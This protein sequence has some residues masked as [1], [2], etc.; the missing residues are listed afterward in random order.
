MSV[1]QMPMLHR[2]GLAYELMIL[3]LLYHEF[4]QMLLILREQ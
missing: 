3:A 1:W 4:M 2:Y